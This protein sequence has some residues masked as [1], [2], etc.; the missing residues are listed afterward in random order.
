MDLKTYFNDM[1]GIQSPFYLGDGVYTG[2]DGYH[3]WLIAWNGISITNKVALDPH[4]LS[5]FENYIAT[6]K[7]NNDD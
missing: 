7:E 6:L 4:A 1:L 3:V 5:A 2:F